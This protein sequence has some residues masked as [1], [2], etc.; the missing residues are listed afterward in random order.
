MEWYGQLTETSCKMH[1]Y[2]KFDGENWHEV[3]IQELRRYDVYRISRD[4]KY[5]E[6]WKGSGTKYI[7]WG[8]P[9]KDNDEWVIECNS[10]SEKYLDRL[11][12]G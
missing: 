9:Y 4:G 10:V 12:S 8:D 3:P 11:K 5:V 7:A 1:V 2:E 6:L